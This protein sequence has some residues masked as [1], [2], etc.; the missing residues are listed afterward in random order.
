[1]VKGGTKRKSKTL[2]SSDI[3]D[4]IL[5]KN[6]LIPIMT[7]GQARDTANRGFGRVSIKR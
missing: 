7:L 4:L 3:L 2:K 5:N 1:M 6:G